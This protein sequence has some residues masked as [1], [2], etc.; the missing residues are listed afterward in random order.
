MNEQRLCQNVNA[1]LDRLTYAN[2]SIHIFKSIIAVY[3]NQEQDLLLPDMNFWRVVC[4]NCCFRA[5]AELAKTYDEGKDS[6]GLQKLLNQAEQTRPEESV[7]ELVKAAR[8]SY[9][10][11]HPL[12][13]KLKILRDKGLAHS[14]KEYASNLKLLVSE[15]GMPLEDIETLIRTAAEIC[16]DILVAFTGTGRSIE[17]FLNDDANG[18]IHDLRIAR[19][20]SND[21]Y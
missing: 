15:H 9:S 8:E 10:S 21:R 13:D 1:L 3:D 17:L 11:L 4:D 19:G 5:L 16:S 2:S 6:I 12:R 20:K 14:D 18:I 7:R